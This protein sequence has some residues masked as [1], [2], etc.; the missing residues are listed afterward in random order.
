MLF[1][2]VCSFFI[3]VG[4]TGTLIIFLFKGVGEGKRSVM[5][6]KTNSYVDSNGLIESN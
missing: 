2:K 5:V 3:Y 6:G 1:V 4:Q